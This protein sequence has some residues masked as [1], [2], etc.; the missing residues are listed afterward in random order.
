[1]MGRQT[2]RSARPRFTPCAGGAATGVNP[3][4]DASSPAPAHTA[5]A[6]KTSRSIAALHALCEL[7]L[8]A[9]VLVPA[10]LEALHQVVPSYR[11]LFDWT[12]AQG[13]L[14]R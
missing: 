6:M 11:N 13:R 10:V 2:V 4:V 5:A 1:M 7:K 12:D 3:R 9:E 14:V 8:H